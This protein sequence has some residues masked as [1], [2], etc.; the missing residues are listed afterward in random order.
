MVTDVDGAN[1]A[2]TL[3]SVRITW[4]ILLPSFGQMNHSELGVA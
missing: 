4:E 2:D 3:Q 1:M